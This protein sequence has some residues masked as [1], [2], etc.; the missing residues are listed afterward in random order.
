MKFLKEVWIDFYSKEIL[1]K[2]TEDLSKISKNSRNL[3]KNREFYESFLKNYLSLEKFWDYF[4][5]K[6]QINL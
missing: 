6:S 1:G 3:K 2:K 5:E 4:S